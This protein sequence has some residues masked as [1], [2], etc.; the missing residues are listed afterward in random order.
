MTH[1]P[2]RRS[3]AL[4]ITA[5]LVAATASLIGFCVTTLNL[6][7]QHDRFAYGVVVAGA[8]AMFAAA[9]IAAIRVP[10]RMVRAMVVAGALVIG[11]A[12]LLGTP[13]TS[14]DSARY[15]WDGIVAG[16]GI[17]PYDHV[18]ADE[19]LAGLRPEWLFPAPVRTAGGPEQCTGT[20]IV[21]TTSVPSDK[22]LCTAIN[23]AHSPTIYP[24]MAEL[25]FLGVRLVVPPSAEYR[26]FQVA[27][28]AVSLLISWMLL[29]ALRRHGQN[30]RWATL[31]AWSPFVALEAVN[32]SHV[33]VLAVA[34]ALA[35]TLLVASGRRVWGGVALGASIATKLVPLIVAPPLLRRRPL[36]VVAASVATFAG[37]YLPYVLASGPRVLGYLPGYLAEEG[38]DNGSRFALLGTVLPA[39]WTLPVAAALLAILAGV[40]LWWADPQAPW[41]AQLVLVGATVLVISPRYP[42]YG[43]LLLPFIVLT[44]RWEWLIVPLALTEWQVRPDII[45]FR[46]A[47][48][49]AAI[50]VVIGWAIRRS[51]RQPGLPRMAARRDRQHRGI[52]GS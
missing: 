29:N 25:Y 26:P 16:A 39:T 34:L 11:G 27:G 33:D 17:S 36:A 46:V 28:L 19:A 43:L 47:L 23:R 18:P 9:C 22:V 1:A 4:I 45:A 51:K 5:L 6:S 31:W 49:V 35:A 52:R 42:W 48:A 41:L 13:N 7:S 50:T 10:D 30:E 3:P 21:E 14:T 38:Y 44:H 40:C 12:A 24:P 20:H 2:V 15:A 32:N 37:L 8:W